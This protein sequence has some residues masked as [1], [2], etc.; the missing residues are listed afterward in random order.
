[1]ENRLTDKGGEQE[2]EGEMNG[3][4]STDAC[5][6]TL[7][8]RQPVGNCCLAQGTKLGLSDSLERWEWAG[9]WREIQERGAT[10]TPMSNSC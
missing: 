9:H 3:E 10:G 6:P 4:S 1:M 5:T 8:T 2:G 7:V